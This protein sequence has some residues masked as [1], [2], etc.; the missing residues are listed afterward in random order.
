MPRPTACR[1][2]VRGLLS[3]NMQLSSQALGFSGKTAGIRPHLPLDAK[4]APSHCM[5]EIGWDWPQMQE[6]AEFERRIASAL[7]RIER[8]LD[9]GAGG[10]LAE[11]QAALDEERMTNAQLAERL[12]VVG[13]RQAAEKA[14][15]AR[16]TEKLGAAVDQRD[17]VLQEVQAALSAANDE[18]TSL[19]QAAVRGSTLP[20]QINR[21]LLAEV[22]ALRAL[23]VADAAGIA[24]VMAELEPIVAGA[25]ANA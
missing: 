7:D 25:E 22:E 16:L 20:H 13:E 3:R 11:L 10:D 1:F 19:R 23:R 4:A 18:L 8:R 24:A 9:G 5:G 12:R 6:I 15:I 14:E 17:Q 2:D 21:A